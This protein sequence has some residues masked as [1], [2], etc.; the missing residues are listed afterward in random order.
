MNLLHHL[1][2]CLYIA[3]RQQSFKGIVQLEKK[4]YNI[5]KKNLWSIKEDILKN[6]SPVLGYIIKVNGV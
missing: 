2:E 5:K 4:K 3:N 6:F 1:S